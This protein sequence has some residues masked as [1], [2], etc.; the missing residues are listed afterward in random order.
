MPARPGPSRAAAA[1]PV[2]PWPGLA[3]QV[4]GA[5]GLASMTVAQL[6]AAAAAAAAAG[7]ASPFALPGRQDSVAMANGKPLRSLLPAATDLTAPSP[8][9]V[10]SPLLTS[11]ATAPAAATSLLPSAPAPPTASRQ[12]LPVGDDDDEDGENCTQS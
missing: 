6:A 1:A 9:L 10:Q 3:Y 11:E 12:M 8:A 2:A 5:D 7:A 4:P